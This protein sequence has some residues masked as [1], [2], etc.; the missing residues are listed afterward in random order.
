M[1]SY[2]FM[3]SLAACYNNAGTGRGAMDPS[4]N[5]YYNASGAPATNNNNTYPNCYSPQIGGNSAV[6][7]VAAAANYYGGSPNN[8]PHP[9][10]NGAVATTG[11]DYRTAMGGN[12]TVLPLG[13]S[14]PILNNPSCKYANSSS[15]SAGNNNNNNSSALDSGNLP[16]PQD[17]TT[18]SNGSSAASSVCS[19]PRSPPLGGSRGS[20][21]P[22]SNASPNASTTGSQ[23]N[24]RGDSGSTNNSSSGGKNPPHIYPWMKRVHLGQSKSTLFNHNFH[25]R[26]GNLV[27]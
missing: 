6:A 3:N 18:N 23:A 17:L 15:G 9:Q 27:A 7:A 4:G 5:D 8:P 16:S 24:S 21:T 10:V 14:P 13:G 25:A 2:Q 22:N 20:A 1:S 19:T 11:L 26:L 12:N